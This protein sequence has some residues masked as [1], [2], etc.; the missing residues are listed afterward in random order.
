MTDP[1]QIIGASLLIA[2]PIAVAVVAVLASIR[3][4][5][6]NVVARGAISAAI[7]LALVSSSALVSDLVYRLNTTTGITRLFLH[8]G[9]V[10]R[11]F[12]AVAGIATL[13]VVQ[14]RRR[15]E[16]DAVEAPLRAF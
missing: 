11:L 4:K 3:A 1:T 14:F 10:V 5:T 8:P 2:T 7:L 15:K 9:T 12:P 6:R 16:K 13:I